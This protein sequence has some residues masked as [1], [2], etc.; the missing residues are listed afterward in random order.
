MPTDPITVTIARDT[1]GD[2]LAS[3]SFGGAPGARVDYELRAGD[4]GRLIDFADAPGY[5]IVAFDFGRTLRVR[6][7]D[8]DGLPAVPAPTSTERHAR[9]GAAMI[10]ARYAAARAVADGVTDHNTVLGDTAGWRV[11]ADAD[12]GDVRQAIA[13]LIV[14]FAADLGVDP[15]DLTHDV[16]DDID[17]LD[18]GADAGGMTVAQARAV[19]AV[20]ADLGRCHVS[21]PDADG[22]VSVQPLVDDV[23][24]GDAVRIDRAGARV[25]LP[26]NHEGHTS[27]ECADCA[28]TG[29]IDDARLA[30]TYCGASS[31][32]AGA[33][34]VEGVI[35]NVPGVAGGDL[36]RLE[37]IAVYVADQHPEHV[38][39]AEPKYENW[40]VN[41]CTVTDPSTIAALEAAEHRLVDERERMIE[42]DRLMGDPYP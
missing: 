19:Q 14:D 35:L 5:V 21:D 2:Y 3:E 12:A 34:V 18:A 22:V 28:L 25:A 13:R 1:T 24:V 39:D 17:A 42:A 10:V 6:R 29:R 16:I 31:P 33:D 38:P 15:L 36:I 11:G 32:A 20:A 30:H 40:Y 9:E 26:A 41:G 27:L 8:V 37:R 23:E 7:V 4:T